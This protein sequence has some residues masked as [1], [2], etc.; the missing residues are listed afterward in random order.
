MKKKSPSPEKTKDF[1]F[2]GK[3]QKKN[4]FPVECNNNFR[5]NVKFREIQ[6]FSWSCKPR[7]SFVWTLNYFFF[8]KKL[9]SKYSAKLFFFLSVQTNEHRGLHDHEKVWVFRNFTFLRK[10]LLHST[11]NLFFLLFFSKKNK[12][13]CF[14]RTWRFFSFFFYKNPINLFF[15]SEAYVQTR[16]SSFDNG[17]NQASNTHWLSCNLS[18]RSTKDPVWFLACMTAHTFFSLHDTC[19]FCRADLLCD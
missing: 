19:H 3:K 9:R 17:R 11:G 14:F 2:F 10:L 16:V 1:I 15:V 12:I 4:K 18:C 5:R 6:T 13:F 8:E 7:C